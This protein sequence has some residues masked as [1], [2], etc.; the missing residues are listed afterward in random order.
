MNKYF[1]LFFQFDKKKVKEIINNSILNEVKGYVCVVDGNVLATS[2]K[3]KEY[4][5]IINNSLVNICDGSSIAILSSLIHKQKFKS[6]TGS[7]IFSLYLKR[8]YKQFFLGNTE[9]NLRLLKSRLISA[10]LN[11]NNYQFS[12]LPFKDVN[13]F[14]Y[15]SIAKSINDFMPDIVWVSLGAPK[16]ER[17]IHYLLPHI[18]KGILFAIG[19][20]VNFYI[21]NNGNKRAPKWMRMLHLEWFYRL[22][23]EPSK[24]GKRVSNYLFILPKM[25]VNEIKNK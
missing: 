21:G 5:N 2:Y 11:E 16:Q 9:N 12:S 13:D 18:K 10:N 14:D 3:D 23:L 4:Q 17:F 6:F 15:I 25:I 19:A 1:N 22:L 8:D 7:E 24:T 20:S